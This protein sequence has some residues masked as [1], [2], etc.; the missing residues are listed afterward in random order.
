MKMEAVAAPAAEDG[1]E[2]QPWWESRACLI[3]I[4]L[5]TMLPLLYPPVPPLV[6]LL[7]HMGR[8]RVELDF[9][10]SPFLREYYDYHWAPIGNLGVDLLIIP[11]GKL[12]GLEL[13][14]KLILLAIPPLTAAGFLWV[15]REVH[16]R[17][18]PTAFFALPFIYGYPFLFGFANF[19]LSVALAFLAFGLWLRLGRLEKTAL[20]GWLFAPIAIVIFF[21]HTYG[22]GLLGLMC[23][24]ADAVRLHDRGRTWFRAGFEAAMH[25][26]VMAL[27]L[28]AMI[29]WRS[30][31]HGGEIS[32]WFNWKVKWR[33]IYSA[34][35]DR[36]KWFDIGS[37]VAVTLAFL[38]AVVSR[39][40]TLSRNL[41]FSAIVL[42]V[43][44]ALLPRI[45][46][47]SAYADMRLVPY[48]IAVALLAIRFRG[49]PDRRTAHVLA[50]L[51]LAFFGTRTLAN[52]ISL[53]ERA[54]D[55]SAKLEAVKLM[56]A[57]ARV[58]SLV[59][60][61]C[62]E[63]WPSLSNGHLGAM[64][65]VRREGFSNDQWVIDG[66][67]LLQVKYPAG[68]YAAD[69]SQL[70]RPDGCRDPLHRMIG[71]S[72]TSIPRDKFDFVW[73][74]DPPRYDPA[75]VADMKLVWRGPGSFLYQTRP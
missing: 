70:V 16:G 37:L 54:N 31:T 3:A 18:P 64:V 57:G 62:Q 36:W 29:I 27:P 42:L 15:A 72:L 7:G 34:L 43:C 68:Y 1:Q 39:K 22:W 19:T 21:C 35:R 60:M 14:V 11:L 48:L 45:I 33:W 24:S 17:I 25:T 56:P 75:A 9:S 51:G 2:A 30:E 38:Y 4:V 50:V 63:Y 49:A 13:A 5:L 71:T 66:I 69:P 47:G 74:I 6:D 61:P 67:N 52:T 65:V 73:L 59:G 8:Y 58:A 55:Q 26:S 40:L 23:F 46:F 12:L 10:Q 41:A 44:F 28:L 32:D 20:R 53:A